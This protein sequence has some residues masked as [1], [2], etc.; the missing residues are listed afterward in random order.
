MVSS[1]GR[2]ILYMGYNFNRHLDNSL[3]LLYLGYLKNEEGLSLT[4]TLAIEIETN[5][6]SIHTD[7]KIYFGFQIEAE[8]IN[9]QP[10]TMNK[11]SRNSKIYQSTLDKLRKQIKLAFMQWTN[12]LINKSGSDEYSKWFNEGYHKYDILK[13]IIISYT[14]ASGQHGGCADIAKVPREV[15]NFIVPIPTMDNLCFWGALIMIN[16]KYFNYLKCE[17]YYYRSR[18]LKVKAGFKE[19]DK[20]PVFF[21]QIQDICNKLKI[22]VN[23]F[24]VQNKKKNTTID[25]EEGFNR[26]ICLLPQNIYYYSQDQDNLNPVF[27]LFLYIKS[28]LCHYYALRDNENTDKLLEFTYLQSCEGCSRFVDVSKDEN[29]EHHKKCLEKK[30]VYR[31]SNIEKIYENKALESNKH[32]SHKTQNTQKKKWYSDDIYFCDFETIGK[33]NKPDDIN[34][35]NQRV[36]CAAIMPIKMIKEY[37]ENEKEINL[38]DIK[39]EQFYSEELFENFVDY[40]LTF[41]KGLFVFFNGSRFDFWFIIP[42]LMKKKI[43]FNFEKDSKTGKINIFNIG[44]L[45]FMD[46]LNFMSGSLSNCC[47]SFDVPKKYVKKDFDHHRI[48]SRDDYMALKDEIIEYC[49]YDIICLGFIYYKYAVEVF[50]SYKLNIRD[51]ISIPHLSYTIWF[52]MLEPEYQD[53][54]KNPIDEAHQDLSKCLYGGRTSPGAEYYIHPLWSEI[55]YTKQYLK[56]NFERFKTHSGALCYIDV[57]SLYPTSMKTFPVPCGNIHQFTDR[58]LNAYQSLF[59]E[60]QFGIDKKKCDHIRKG[61]YQVDVRCPKNLRIAYLPSRSEQ[62]RLEWNLYDK[63]KQWYDG[64]TLLGAIQRG[65]IVEKL[66]KGYRFTQLKDLLGKYVDYFY[67]E[68]AKAKKEKNQVKYEMFKL[69]LNALYGKFGQEP[70]TL[71]SNIYYDDSFFKD[72]HNLDD[73]DNITTWFKDNELLAYYVTVKKNDP[74]CYNKNPAIGSV[75]LSGSKEIM[76]RLFEAFECVYEDQVSKNNHCIYY[77][78]TD[79]ILVEKGV[80]DK[81]RLKNSNLNLYGDD[82]GQVKD[83]LPEYVILEAYFTAPKSYALK[84]MNREGEICIKCVTK[85]APQ[86]SGFM[87]RMVREIDLD[88]LDI[89]HDFE[90]RFKSVYFVLTDQNG[91]VVEKKPYLP[92]N[93][94][95]VWKNPFY[96]ILVFYGSMKKTLCDMASGWDA[97]TIKTIQNSR[98]INQTIWEGRIFDKENNNSYPL[99]FVRRH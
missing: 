22:N 27:N 33:Y 60:A 53:F 4:D 70:H 40:I 10:G 23:I 66:Y 75:I 74:K 16:E 90:D 28:R 94:W 48:Q 72:I 36:Y 55:L 35:D 21:N 50:N 43:D 26:R 25:Y 11:I 68:K 6:T 14:S 39:C 83:E 92:F 82:L 81:A 34:V 8:M 32:K 79:S 49:K 37:L 17:S 38:K 46:M 30:K 18:E 58:D 59:T 85:G 98:T 78:D 99:G 76:F 84:C 77:T 1:P 44:K 3:H 24:T 86:C 71:M 9:Y 52:N 93:W 64:Y 69:L 95:A 12:E 45:K 91:L 29:I 20:N 15:F 63:N 42:V 47:K 65:Y 56:D 80:I 61:F 57:N 51:Y 41:K 96:K 97:L 73:L 19:D 87:D 62:G 13:L 67:K 89:S 88:A 54:I 7:V 2:H 5:Y 31:M